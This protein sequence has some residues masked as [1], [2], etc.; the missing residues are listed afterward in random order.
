MSQE[1]VGSKLPVNTQYADSPVLD[2]FTRV[3][4]S[5]PQFN[6]DNQYSYNLN[7]QFMEPVTNGSGATVTFDSTNRVAKMTFASTPTGGK[8]YMQSFQHNHY[9]PGRS[10]LMIC[11]F[12]F[13]SAV[14]NVLK[15]VG[16]SDGTNGIEFQLDGSTKQWKLSSSTS[17][18]NETVTQANWNVDRLDGT[19]ASGITLDVTKDQIVIIDIQALY[20]G[21]VRVG[22]I[23]DGVIFYCHFFQHTNLLTSPFIQRASL[24]V[25]CGMTCTGTVSTTM[26]MTCTTVESEGADTENVGNP[27]SVEGTATAGNGARTHLLSV[28]PKTTFNGITN[29]IVFELN[30]LEFL[31]TGN[32]PI[33]WELCV[34]QAISGT[35]TFNDVNTT[36]SGFEYNTAGTISGSPDI[37]I[38]S[39]YSGGGISGSPTPVARILSQRVPITLDAAGA[40]RALGTVS[41]IVTGIGAN[42]ACRGIM[43][44]KEV[45]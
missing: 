24:P 18:G 45:R 16:Y 13:E 2:A 41:L 7:P 36:Y 40:V 26:H 27:F 37:V 30:G 31:V 33:L 5:T 32:N 4:T 3:R 19:G 44:W 34:G 9:Y 1:F 14:A 20:T 11:S 28:R 38:I 42:T 15:F 6:F 17:S 23:I 29:R 22:F 10:Q 35:T 8:A 12:G 21:R 39:G 43:N 25:R